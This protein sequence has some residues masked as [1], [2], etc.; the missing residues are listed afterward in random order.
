M[1]KR[2]L[3]AQIALERAQLSLPPWKFTPADVDFGPCPYAPG[4]GG[5]LYWPEAVALRRKI[6][7]RDPTFYDRFDDDR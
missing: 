4:T 6:L 3:K 2:S 1:V 5:F 7:E